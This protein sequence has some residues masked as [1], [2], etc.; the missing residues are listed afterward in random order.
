MAPGVRG[1]GRQRQDGADA[2]RQLHVHACAPQPLELDRRDQTRRVRDRAERD[3]D[4]ERHRVVL[5]LVRCGEERRVVAVRVRGLRERPE[6]AVDRA[7]DD[8]RACDRLAR[9][10]R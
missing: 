2:G 10:R 8:G 3:L 4:A 5:R 6:V 9:P 7:R 1:R